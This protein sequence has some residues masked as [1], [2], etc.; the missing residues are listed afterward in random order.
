MSEPN[1]MTRRDAAKLAVGATAAAVIAAP[2]MQDLDAAVHAF[3]R[4]AG[5]A[6]G[7]Q[8]CVLREVAGA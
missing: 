3:P 5:C 8:A 1:D 6:V 7:G 2:W 4:H